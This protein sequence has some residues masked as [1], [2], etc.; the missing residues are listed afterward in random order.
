MARRRH[1]KK[2]MLEPVEQVDDAGLDDCV[3][4]PA[5]VTAPVAPVEDVPAAP[6]AET[7]PDETTEPLPASGPRTVCIINPS[8]TQKVHVPLA[9]GPVR[10]GPKEQM[11]VSEADLTDATRRA[12]KAGALFIRNL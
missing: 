4:D 1:P 3:V 6:V 2:D 7:V 11:P 12:E 10:L 9:G 5:D 8:M